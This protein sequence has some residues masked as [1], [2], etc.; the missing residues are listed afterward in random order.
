MP[1]P[2]KTPIKPQIKTPAL[3]APAKSP[4]STAAATPGTPANAKQDRHAMFDRR[5]KNHDGRLSLEEFL[6]GQPDPAEAPKRFPT[7]DTNKDGF[8]SREEF[9][10]SGGQGPKK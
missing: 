4:A 2:I 7:F 3:G 6:D 5:D 1:P 9:V 10:N 8:L